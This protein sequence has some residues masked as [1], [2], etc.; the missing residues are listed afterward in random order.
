MCRRGNAGLLALVTAL[1]ALTPRAFADE[2]EDAALVHMDRGTAAF[3]AKEYVRAHREFEAA[4]ELVPDRA[5][6]YRWLALTEMQLG[7]C[8]QA[9]GNIAEFERRVANDDPRLAELQRLRVLCEQEHMTAAPPPTTTPPPPPPRSTP[10]HERAWFWPAVAG[11]GVV[12][13]GG[14]VA[15]F[16][17][18]GGDDITTLPPV[19]CTDAGCS[20]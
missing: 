2:N 19:H 10:I 8:A 18:S 11:A 7:D 3:S 9:V 1:T 15:A 16:A 12:V 17:L 5:N 14:I 20:P 6:P 4:H 13:V